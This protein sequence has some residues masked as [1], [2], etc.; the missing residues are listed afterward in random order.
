MKQYRQSGLFI[1]IFSGLMESSVM[2]QTP[3]G[4]GL[5]PT[6]ENLNAGAVAAEVDQQREW[7]PEQKD[8]SVQ[9]KT[10]SPTSEQTDMKIMVQTVTFSGMEDNLTEEELQAVVQAELGKEKSVADLWSMAG[11]VTDYLHSKG[12]MAALAILPPQEIRNGQVKMEI[13]MGHYDRIGVTNQSDLLTERAVSLTHRIRPGKIIEKDSLDRTLLTLNDIPGLR[14]QAYLSP[15]RTNG[16]AEL[17]FDLTTT[18]HNRG[19]VYTDNYGSRYTGRWRVGMAWNWNN[20]SHTGDQLYASYLHSET[21][22]VENYDIRYEIPVGNDGTVLGIE[23]YRTDYVLGR[24][25]SVYDAYGKSKSWK[26]FTK[27]PLKLSTLLPI[28]G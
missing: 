15:G 25:Y 14:A 10:S 17:L 24:Q 16:T 21:G 6:G 4:A 28:H 1:L 27:T 19:Y 13:L 2:A 18:E 5:V 22:G 20:I 23:N 7:I 8:V 12:Y 11:K 3:Q 9:F 26:I